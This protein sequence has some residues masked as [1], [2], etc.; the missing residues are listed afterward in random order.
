MDNKTLISSIVSVKAFILVY[1]AVL[2]LQGDEIW[3]LLSC[4]VA[5]SLIVLLINILF[6]R[7][8]FNLKINFE[9]LNRAVKPKISLGAAARIL[10]LEILL[11]K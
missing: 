6:G 7:P 4:L 3:N 9:L 1:I 5:N 10:N 11:N 8:F 2:Y